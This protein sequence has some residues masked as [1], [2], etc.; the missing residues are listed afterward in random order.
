VTYLNPKR[1]IRV[2]T[3]SIINI[4][5]PTRRAFQTSC[6]NE[7]PRITPTLLSRHARLLRRQH[8]ST[9][10]VNWNLAK[11]CI[12]RDILSWG[13]G[14]RELG[15]PI[16]PDSSMSKAGKDTV[17]YVCTLR[18]IGGYHGGAAEKELAVGVCEEGFVGEFPGRQGS[19]D[20]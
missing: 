9:T 10:D 15:I 14:H 1:S 12:D 17:S 11:R 6:R 3:F 18:E 5:L 4:Q 19:H 7:T 2:H 16:V 13:S 8:A 20:G